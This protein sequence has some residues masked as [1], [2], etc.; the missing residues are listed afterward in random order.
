VLGVEA[1]KHR[2]CSRL[3]QKY[4]EHPAMGEFTETGGEDKI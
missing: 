4:A 3:L 2:I 1:L